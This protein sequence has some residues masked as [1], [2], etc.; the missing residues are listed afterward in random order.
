MS[1]VCGAIIDASELHDRQFDAREPLQRL[2]HGED[3]RLARQSTQVPV[4]DEHDRLT[5]T[6]GERPRPPLM[7]HKFDGR[8][9]IAHGDAHARSVRRVRY[10]PH[11][12]SHAQR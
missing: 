6:S 7:I 8:R 1:T 10:A 5:E 2:A 3:V 4:K 11:C 12:I 9:P